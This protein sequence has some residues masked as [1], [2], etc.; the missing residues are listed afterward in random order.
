MVKIISVLLI[1][2]FADVRAQLFDF[3][4]AFQP[5]TLRPIFEPTKPT[6]TTRFFDTNR[7]QNAS[8]KLGQSTELTTA[9]AIR[10]TPKSNRRS[11]NKT[12][13]IKENYGPDKIA[14]DDGY[15]SIISYDTVKHTTVNPFARPGVKPAVVNGPPITNRPVTRSFAP[16]PIA[17]LQPH[18][19]NTVTPEL[20][21]GPDEDYMST[22]ERRR[23]MEV[24]EKK[25]EQYV[26]LD[27]VRV[28]AI[29]LVPSPRPV[30]VN[31][32][33]CARSVPLVVG[34]SVVTI[35]QFPHMALLG[36]T[37]MRSGGY[38]WKCEA[39]AQQW[40]PIG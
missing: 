5:Q 16:R 34:G 33:S 29:P 8:W 23:F 38:L 6:R 4:T 35:Q 24:T 1:I 21:V 17:G 40:A 12:K 14:F 26:S 7:T 20:I 31:V 11:Q 22:V 32:S 13:K 9:K 30:V 19:D 28:E 25:C 18:D 36:W 2:S 3:L 10:K 27:T 37:R 15:N 39:F